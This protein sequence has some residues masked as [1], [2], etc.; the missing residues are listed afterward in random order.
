[1]APQRRRLPDWSVPSGWGESPASGPPQSPWAWPRNCCR[2][3]EAS[4]DVRPLNLASSSASAAVR[5]AVRHPTVP[6]AR[7]PPMTAYF[8][9]WLSLLG[10][11]LHLWRASPGSARP[12]ISSGSTITSFHRSIRCSPTGAWPGS[13]GRCMAAVSTM[14]TSTA[15]RPRPCV[16]ASLVLL[17]GLHHLPVRRLSVVSSLLRPGEVYLIDRRWQLCRNPRPSP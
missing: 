2:V 6:P 15:W 16:L 14:R 1:M 8:L 10:R 17:G 3:L 13:C 5:V 4:V 11:W 9:D 12:S 7:P